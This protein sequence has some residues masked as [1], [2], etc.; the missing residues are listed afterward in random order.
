MSLLHTVRDFFHRVSA[1]LRPTVVRCEAAAPPAAAAP[2]TPSTLLVGADP[3]SY[4]VYHVLGFPECPWFHRASC[5]A[6]D[7]ERQPEY[8][9]SI[10]VLTWPIARSEYAAKLDGLT[11]VRRAIL[12]ACS[13]HHVSRVIDV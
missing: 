11:Q 1:P 8:E 13:R 7:L 4:T 6:Q 10:E 5:I 9:E 3:E 2:A 12:A